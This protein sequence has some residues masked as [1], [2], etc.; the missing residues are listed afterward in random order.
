[1]TSNAMI[2]MFW[3]K[4]SLVSAEYF[5]QPD[6]AATVCVFVDLFFFFKYNNQTGHTRVL[7]SVTVQTYYYSLPQHT[8]RTSF[9]ENCCVENVRNQKCVEVQWKR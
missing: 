5:A 4:Q 3:I 8:H 7:C 6:D 1:M 9:T 2:D